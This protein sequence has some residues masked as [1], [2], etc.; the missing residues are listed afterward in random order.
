MELRGLDA[1]RASTVRLVVLCDVR[2]SPLPVVVGLRA[3]WRTGGTG[4]A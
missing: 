2:V 1:L 3:A 4:N